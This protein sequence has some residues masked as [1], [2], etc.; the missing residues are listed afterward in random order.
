[1]FIFVPLKK[2]MKLIRL[3]MIV[4]VFILINGCTGNKKKATISGI[5]ANAEGSMLYG[6]VVYTNKDL[7][8]DSV[9]LTKTGDFS[10]TA[11]IEQPSFVK[12]YLPDQSFNSLLLFPGDVITVHARAGN[13][14]FSSITGSAESSIITEIAKT[15]NHFN[16]KLDSI[17]TLY[18]QIHNDPNKDSVIREI[19]QLY[20]KTYQLTKKKFIEIV[21]DNPGSL[22]ATIAFLLPNKATRDFILVWKENS[23]LLFRHDSLLRNKYTENEYVNTFHE[24]IE[25]FRL[26]LDMSGNNDHVLR[27]KAPEISLPDTSGNTINLYSVLGD[28]TLV[29]I[30]ASWNRESRLLNKKWHNLYQKYHDKGFEIYHVS[31][32]TKK[33]TWQTASLEDQI[34]WPNVSDL[35][36]YDS[37]VCNVYKFKEVP[38]NYLIDS[39]GYI[40]GL[41]IDPDTLEKIL[42]K[43]L[44]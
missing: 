44:K 5:I 8:F 9:R 10:F 15:E 14:V 17:Q 6:K 1:M 38:A 11:T 28:I 2:N 30:W 42:R 7:I 21:R 12:I 25:R 13:T 22:A 19:Q 41:N 40:I 24:R 29:Q 43:Q 39:A 23:E 18:Q 36:K 3:L 27:K 33:T 31:M 20:N 37:P 4:Q 32:D 35:K 16:R 26:Q 34:Q